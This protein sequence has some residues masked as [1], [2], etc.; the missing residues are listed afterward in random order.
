MGTVYKH[1]QEALLMST[2]NI[3]FCA[4]IKKKYIYINTFWRKNALYLE[5]CTVL[6]FAMPRYVYDIKQDI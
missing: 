6:T 1:L 4:D 5:L 2:H 3:C